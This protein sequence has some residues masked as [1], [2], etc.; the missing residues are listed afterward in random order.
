MEL[1]ANNV[2]RAIDDIQH[3]SFRFKRYHT[4][5]HWSTVVSG[6]Y[7]IAQFYLPP[8]IGDASVITQTEAGTRFIYP[9]GRKAES[10]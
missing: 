7:E 4:R 10:T 1:I 9:D 2:E 5:G 8:D 3:L 6:L